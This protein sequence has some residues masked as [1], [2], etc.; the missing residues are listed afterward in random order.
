MDEE[1]IETFSREY[2]A[3]KKLVEKYI[4]HLK[5]LDIKKR[6]RE[7]TRKKQKMVDANKGM[8]DYDWERL[9]QEGKL[10]CLN[11][12]VL[13]MYLREKNLKVPKGMLKKGKLELVTADI[14]RS[15]IKR[16]TTAERTDEHEGNEEEHS[17]EEEE[18]I[19]LEQIGDT[20]SDRE[21]DCS[22]DNEDD[23]DENESESDIDD[24]NEDDVLTSLF[25]TTRFG[26][27]ATTWKKQFFQ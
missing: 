4:Q 15:V 13:D 19:I 14:A 9:Y 7:E 26:R 17:D 8:K 27:T 21:S 5:Y 16:L 6:K 20:D 10:K 23:V 2:V 25:H 24:R 3:D 12:S 11:V 22:S 18:D 1:V